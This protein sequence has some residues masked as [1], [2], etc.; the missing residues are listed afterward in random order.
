MKNRYSLA[1]LFVLFSLA[2]NAQLTGITPNQGVHM[3]TLQTTITSNGL[4]IQSSSPGGNIYEIKLTKGG[5][6]I[7]VF[8]YWNW[9]TNINVVDANTVTIDMTIP[10]SVG[11]GVYDLGVTT[12]DVWD[13]TW[14]QSFDFLPGAFTVL[15]PDGYVTGTVYNDLNQNGVKDGGES[16]FP[17]SAVKLLPLNYT[18]N[19]DA[20]GNYSFPVPNGNYSVAAFISNSNYLFLTSANDTLPVTVNNNTA[21]G[22]DFGYKYAL[23]SITPN[24]GYRGVSTTH[25]LV[26][27]EPIFALGGGQNGNVSQFRVL[28]S[29]NVSLNVATSVTVIDAYT[30]QV[31]INIPANVSVANN[32]DIRIYTTS[33]SIGYHYLNDQF[34]IVNP[35]AFV[36]ALWKTTSPSPSKVYIDGASSI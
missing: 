33:G 8:E 9:N 10:Y 34:N 27:D 21:S 30:I 36:S 18:L 35:P 31:A 25:Q 1:C 6:V 7:T 32:V 5:D 19:T 15:P 11:A 16:G 28:S 29:P 24:T 17:G 3:Q 23:T 13:P 22:N 4:F 26:A 20:S 12:G 14:N 2:V